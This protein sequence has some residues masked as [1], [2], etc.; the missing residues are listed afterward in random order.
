MVTWR[1]RHTRKN[2]MWQQRQRV[3][4]WN[5]HPRNVTNCWQTTEARKRKARLQRE[6][7]LADTL[8]SNFQ[9]PKLW[10]KTFMLFQVIQAVVFCNRRPMKLTQAP[11][12]NRQ[13]WSSIAQLTS[14]GPH[15]GNVWIILL[16]VLAI[17]TTLTEHVAKVLDCHT[18]IA[19]GFLDQEVTWNCY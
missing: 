7:G 10:D 16:D 15:S 4:L 9:P 2:T 6:D 3:E 17:S 8:V 19:T 5:F 12:N 1:Q 13:H 11:A 14:S 18:V